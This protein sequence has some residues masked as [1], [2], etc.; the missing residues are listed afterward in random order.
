MAEMGSAI[1][2]LDPAA[3]SGVVAGTVVSPADEAWD[4]ARAAWNLAADQRPA[5]VAYVESPDDVVRA[6]AFARANGLRVAA[7][8]TGLVREWAATAPVE[9]TSIARFLHLPALP[10]VPRP[11]R[12][13]PL[14]TLGAC[15][16]TPAGRWPPPRPALERGRTSTASTSSSGSGWR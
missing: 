14:I 6:M 7:Q 4:K 5:A 9:V 13:R 1:Q 8:G 10:M 11:L 3:L 12:D 15:Y 2:E 16:V